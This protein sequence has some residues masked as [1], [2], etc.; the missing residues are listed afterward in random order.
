MENP[1]SDTTAA[2]SASDRRTAT[3]GDRRLLNRGDAGRR[4][5]DAPPTKNDLAPPPGALAAGEGSPGSY[6]GIIA[7]LFA[8]LWGAVIYANFAAYPL[9][10]SSDAKAE[11]AEAFAAGDN[12]GVY[13][14][15]IDTRGLRRAHIAKL[16]ETPE[17]IVLGAS[18]WQE[19]E[20][21][22]VPHRTFY[23]A[24]VHRDY[25]EDILGVTEMLVANGRLPKTMIISIRD[26]MFTP[27]A[28]RTDDLW[29]PGLQDYRK[30]ARRLGLTP[31]TWGETASA[32]EWL[33]LMS[34]KSLGDRVE[35]IL[36]S[37][38]HPGPT[39]EP[40]LETLDLLHRD[41]FIRWSAEHNAL[42]TQERTI[43]LAEQDFE[44]LKRERIT[45]DPRG[46]E[47]L[48]RIL[49]YLVERGVRVV[50][51]HPPYNPVFWDKIVETLYGTDI[52]R[53]AAATADVA[54][55]HGV[56]VYGSFDPHDVGC[57]VSE[58]IDSHHGRTSCLAKIIAQIPGL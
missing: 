56:S 12:Y 51:V 34:L 38:E 8:V 3:Q 19:G 23:N 21:S 20:S 58:F 13:D 49:A 29:R 40:S 39:R 50:L 26:L 27:V 47:A 7:L 55:A 25:Y 14:L 37:S 46:L 32:N 11:V 48:D 28:L 43:D 10:Y 5:E 31:H 33:N 15:N 24:H 1:M 45:I 41:G 16:T 4:P 35:R 53:V 18:H 42:F 30:M 6:L 57:E 52:E 17:V 2:V 9:V 36:K 54:S 44:H 22:L